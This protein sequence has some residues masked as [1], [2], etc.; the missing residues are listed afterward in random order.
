MRTKRRIVAIKEEAVEGIAEALT[1]ADVGAMA[2]E[3]KVDVDITMYER[4]LS[5]SSIGRFQALPGSRFS[6]F[7]CKLEVKGAGSAY[8]VSVLPALDRFFMAC[9]MAKT[10]DA[11]GGSESVTYKPATEGVKSYTIGVFEDGVLQSI[12]G[13]RGSMKIT[14]KSGEPVMA[15]FEFIGVYNG[16]TDVALLSPTYESTIPPIFRSASLLI[17]TYSPIMSAINIDMANVMHLREDVNAAAGYLSTVITDRNVNGDMDPEMVLIA[18][19]DW[20]GI[21]QAG[22][23]GVLSFGDIGSTQYNKFDLTAPK[24]LTTKVSDEDAEG[25]VIASQTFQLA[26]EDGDD[27][28]AIKFD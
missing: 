20:Y 6:T 28:Y 22:T 10:I 9:G 19:Q 14:C 21:W 27:E 18:E 16:V 12:K 25:Q 24:M 5:K 23:T 2:I 13:A 15:E 4:N 11:T 7:T 17:G 26:E 3:P 8:S 1:A